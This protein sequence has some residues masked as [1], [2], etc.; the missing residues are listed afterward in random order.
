MLGFYV[1]VYN[2]LLNGLLCLD[3][4][5]FTFIDLD[6]PLKEVCVEMKRNDCL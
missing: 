1:V 4:N 6:R 5:M 2:D 3:K